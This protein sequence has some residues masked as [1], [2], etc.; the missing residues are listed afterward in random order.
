MTHRNIAAMTMLLL[1]TLGGG[2]QASNDA[3]PV[4]GVQRVRL[5]VA[6]IV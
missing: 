6:G 1:A 5:H 2:V 4:A 3:T